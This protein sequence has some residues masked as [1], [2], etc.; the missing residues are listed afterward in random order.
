MLDRALRN[1]QSS[2]ALP[3]PSAAQR[4]TM[5]CVAQGVEQH[6]VER[7]GACNLA[8]TSSACNSSRRTAF[9][10]HAAHCRRQCAQRAWRRAT[11]S[12]C[13]ASS[14]GDAEPAH[15]VR[16]STTLRSPSGQFAKSSR[17]SHRSRPP[18]GSASA[19][20]T[21]TAAC[22]RLAAV[23]PRDLVHRARL[24]SDRRRRVGEAPAGARPLAEHL[25][26]SALSRATAAASR[27]RRSARRRI[28]AR[29]APARAIGLTVAG[30]SAA[31]RTACGCGGRATPR[32][33]A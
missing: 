19:S 5:P 6:S 2:R 21:R 14:V 15:C 7:P 18:G 12:K 9:A 24:P 30:R 17:T 1:R 20:A 25:R 23:E 22:E 3:G 31:R 10:P 16:L 29:I 27:R 28:G 11:S 13:S 32:W 4:E 8:G 33:T 26:A